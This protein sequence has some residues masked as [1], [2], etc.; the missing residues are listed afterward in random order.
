M[1]RAQEPV[2]P[3][4]R[5]R[6]PSGK[7]HMYRLIDVV[8]AA[9]AKHGSAERLRA[10]QLAKAASAKQHAETRL[11]AG[12][13]AEARKVRCLSGLDGNLMLLLLS[14]ACRGLHRSLMFRSQTSFHGN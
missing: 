2:L 1:W 5:P 12:N 3:Q 13:R 7:K 8:R 4:D 10:C 14:L 6:K 9:R 11:A